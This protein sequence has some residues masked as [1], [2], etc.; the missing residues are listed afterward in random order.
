MLDLST[1]F[2]MRLAARALILA[3]LERHR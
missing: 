2:D 3:A 1:G